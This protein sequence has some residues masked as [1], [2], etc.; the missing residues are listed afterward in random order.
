MLNLH[1]SAVAV[2]DRG[3]LILGP[4]GSGKSGLALRLM[5]LGAR[6]VADDR[7]LLERRGSTLVARAPDALAGLIEARGIGLIRVGSV[8][9]TPVTLAVDLAQP[10]SARLP[11]TREITWLGIGIEL[12]SGRDAPNLHHVLYVIL[13]GG[14]VQRT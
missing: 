12:I 14:S 10:S 2:A 7:V 1:A 11:Q 9:E 13:Q 5:A 4:S 6:L 3:V 8:S